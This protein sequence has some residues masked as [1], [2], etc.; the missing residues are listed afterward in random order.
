M[1]GNWAQNASFTRT[2][3]EHSNEKC[4]SGQILCKQC[5]ITKYVSRFRGRSQDVSESSEALIFTAEVVALENE[6]FIRITLPYLSPL[7]MCQCKLHNPEQCSCKKSVP[8]VWALLSRHDTTS[9]EK[10]VW[11]KMSLMLPLHCSLKK[12]NKTIPGQSHQMA[13]T[14]EQNTCAL[15]FEHKFWCTKCCTNKRLQCRHFF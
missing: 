13:T 1:P 9:A 8:I 4:L 3:Q 11:N 12:K 5:N 15:T 7:H 10:C 6:K 14:V 2:C